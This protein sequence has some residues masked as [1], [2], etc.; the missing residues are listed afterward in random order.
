MPQITGICP[1]CHK[2]SGWT[3]DEPCY[4]CVEQEERQKRWEAFLESHKEQIKDFWC[5]IFNAIFPSD[6]FGNL[7]ESF[8]EDIKKQ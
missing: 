5:A 1:K 8:Y 6:K 4:K 3:E 2:Y 7:N